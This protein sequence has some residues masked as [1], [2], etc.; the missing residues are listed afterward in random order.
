ML[1]AD[2]PDE[3]AW[4]AAVCTSEH[5]GRPI[6]VQI[7]MGQ[8][9]PWSHLDTSNPGADNC[10]GIP[11]VYPACRPEYAEEGVP[12]AIRRDFQ[13]ALQCQAA[14][15]KFGAALV[16]RRVL[17]A[18]VRERGGSGRNLELE[19]DSL[20]PDVLNAPLKESAH[21]VRHV[22]NEAAHAEEVEDEDVA[23]LLEFTRDVLHS[24]Y[25]V[26][27]RVANRPKRPEKKK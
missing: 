25:V 26:P 20:S 14:G 19:I 23:A 15:F 10:H 11:E 27:H 6:L 3:E 4:L 24:L 21:D 2:L 18:A 8:G 17:Q 16:G 1:I 13:E 5:C 12:E 22:G 7:P 9:W